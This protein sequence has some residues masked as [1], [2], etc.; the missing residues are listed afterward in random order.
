[1]SALHTVRCDGCHREQLSTPGE[2]LGAHR[3]YLRRTG[4]TMRRRARDL[5]QDFCAYCSARIA[6]GETP[7]P[8]E[9][10][11][12]HQPAPDPLEESFGRER[13]LVGYTIRQRPDSGASKETP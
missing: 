7:R 5:T 9:V 8:V 13:R 10:P 2:T 3:D 12:P 4:W 1:M 6:A 11:R